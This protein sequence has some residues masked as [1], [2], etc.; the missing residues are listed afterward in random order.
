MGVGGVLNQVTTPT[1]ADGSDGID[2][3]RDEPTDM[4]R[5]PPAVWGVSAASSVSGD[6]ASVAGD[7]SA[8]RGMP[9]ACTTAAA[10]AKKV[11]VGMTT[12]RP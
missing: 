8:S 11:L 4:D 3:R 12:S 5:G 10:V 7:T 6:R 2:L 9:P 1:I